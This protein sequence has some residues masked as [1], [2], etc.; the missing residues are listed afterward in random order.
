LGADIYL[1]S[2]FTP[3]AEALE[4][5][6]RRVLRP[7]ESMTDASTRF[8]DRLRGSGGYFRNGYNS[9][10][11]MH[12]MGLSWG[13]VGNM[14]DDRKYL[15]V[16]R[17][18]ELIALIEARPLTRDQAIAV[19]LGDVSG[20]ARCA[21]KLIEVFSD[22]MPQSKQY[23]PPATAEIDRGLAFLIARRDELL[24]ILR[25]SVELNEPLLCSL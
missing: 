13:I 6:P 3:F 23:Q 25:K 18:R 17:A 19:M 14:L 1:E 11:V 22:K 24:A 5:E 2:I 12:A 4:R 8:Y 20:Q 15:P 21:G 9:G 7:G 16:E 10:D